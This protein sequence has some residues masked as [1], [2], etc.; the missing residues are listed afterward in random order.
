MFLIKINF[1]IL[2]MK[3]GGKS[4]FVIIKGMKLMLKLYIFWYFNMKLLGIGM[5]ISK[6]WFFKF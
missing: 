3:F 2:M 1:D 6:K 4:F 5:K